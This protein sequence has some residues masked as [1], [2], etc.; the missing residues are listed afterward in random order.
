MYTN[1]FLFV[2]GIVVLDWIGFSPF[3]L[4]NGTL[5]YFFQKTNLIFQQSSVILS[6]SSSCDSLRGDL[7]MKD[8]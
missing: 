3:L 2:C 6:F 4:L 5:Q 7:K 1:C 8:L